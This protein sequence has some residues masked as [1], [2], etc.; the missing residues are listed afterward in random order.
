MTAARRRDPDRGLD[1][2]SS[3]EAA[4]LGVLQVDLTGASRWP[5]PDLEE[6]VRVRPQRAICI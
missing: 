4:E 3:S 1:R 6:L 2:A 5:A